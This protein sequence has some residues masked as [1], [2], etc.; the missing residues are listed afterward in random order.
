[1]PR[2]GGSRGRGGT[3]RWRCVLYSTGVQCPIFFCALLLRGLTGA[4]LYR[5]AKLV[6]V[7]GL[8][9]F[10]VMGGSSQQR[11]GLHVVRLDQ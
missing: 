11:Q 3:K 9:L 6:L 4:G 10:N 2:R 1:M 5:L 7:C 8:G